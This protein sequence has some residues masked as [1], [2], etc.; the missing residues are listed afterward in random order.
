MK[1]L[2]FKHPNKVEFAKGQVEK[3]LEDLKVNLENFYRSMRFGL[4]DED[5]KVLDDLI[6][7]GTTRPEDALMAVELLDNVI[8]SVKH[9]IDVAEVSFKR[10]TIIDENNVEIKTHE[11]VA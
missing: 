10:I 11:E 6:E 7:C 2:T 4:T 1:T 5:K 8:E 9:G 3:T